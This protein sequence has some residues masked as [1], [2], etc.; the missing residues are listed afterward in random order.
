MFNKR[1]EPPPPTGQTGDFRQPTAQREPPTAAVRPNI[2]TTSSQWQPTQ[3]Q[4]KSFYT[5]R[6]QTAFDPRHRD[7]PQTPV[8]HMYTTFQRQHAP[9]STARPAFRSAE[10]P[11]PLDVRKMSPVLR[12]LCGVCGGHF[13][14][15]GHRAQHEHDAHGYRRFDWDHQMPGI[16]RITLKQLGAL[17]NFDHKLVDVQRTAMGSKRPDDQRDAT[18]EEIQRAVAR[19]AEL[20]QKE[21]AFPTRMFTCR[22]CG[23]RKTTAEKAA[24]HAT[25]HSA[26]GFSCSCCGVRFPVSDERNAHENRGHSF[27]RQEGD[28]VRVEAIRMTAEEIEKA[29][30]FAKNFE[31]VQAMA[32]D[33]WDMRERAPIAVMPL[34]EPVL[35]PKAEEVVVKREQPPVDVIELS[36]D[37]DE[38]PRSPPQP[39]VP[40]ADPQLSTEHEHQVQAA[41]NSAAEVPTVDPPP[42]VAEVPVEKPEETAVQAAAQSE[43]TA[44]AICGFEAAN[45]KERQEHLTGHLRT[46]GFSCSFCGVLSKKAPQRNRHELTHHGFERLPADE[47]FQGAIEIPPD[48]VDKYAKIGTNFAD[49]QMDAKAA[50]EAVEK[51]A[52]RKRRSKKCKDCGLPSTAV[53]PEHAARHALAHDHFMCAV[54]GG[55]FQRMEARRV[56]EFTVHNF[57]RNAADWETKEAVVIPQET[58]VQLRNV[59]TNFSAVQSTAVPSK[60]T[61][62]STRRTDHFFRQV[63]RNREKKTDERVERPVF[64]QPKL[65][66]VEDEASGGSGE[67]QKKRAR[68]EGGARLPAAPIDPVHEAI[69]QLQRINAMVKME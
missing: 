30:V 68:V 8:R 9:Q 49:V 66:P 44:C 45:P 36:D 14:S 27:E 25:L 51:P 3:D 61:D 34:E 50:G 11:N 32:I 18:A 37:N 26:A 42:N 4:T 29:H 40:V 15:A 57:E 12:F 10:S 1:A 53:S 69:R 41:A 22:E 55:G 23:V 35:P 64:L 2:H 20:K 19:Q 67:L 54:C 21:T 65:E 47:A 38:S 62:L 58:F 7:G 6:R 16:V 33:P 5:I 31:Q 52:K 43:L 17:K 63:E 60:R 48:D 24:A 56:H 13:V 59:T 39:T 28:R 46:R